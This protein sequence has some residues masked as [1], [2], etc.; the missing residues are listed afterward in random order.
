[1]DKSMSDVIMGRALVVDVKFI[2]DI[3]VDAFPPCV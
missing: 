1:M 3:W 2:R